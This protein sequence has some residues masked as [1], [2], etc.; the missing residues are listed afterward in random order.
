MKQH[1][2]INEAGLRILELCE[3]LRLKAYQCPAGK[4]TI[5]YGHTGPD[6]LPDS[7]ITEKHAEELLVDDVAEAKDA[8]NRLV[9][10]RISHNQFSAL[11]CFVYNVGEGNFKAS[12]LLRMLNLGQYKAAADQ[13]MRWTKAGGKELPGLV[14]RRRAEKALFED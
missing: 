4:W 12:T 14:S 7:M 13:F 5:G 8:V 6:V 10:V 1:D 9:K 11:V 2:S 3:G